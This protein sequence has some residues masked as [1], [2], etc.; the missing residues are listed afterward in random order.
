MEYLN[1]S[2]NVMV[3][4]NNIIPS[5]EFE[6]KI[7]Y[8]NITIRCSIKHFWSMERFIYTVKRKAREELHLENDFDIVEGRETADKIEA[9]DT[10]TFKNKYYKNIPY[11]AF[12]IR[13]IEIESQENHSYQDEED[14]CSICLEIPTERC[15]QSQVPFRCRHSNFCRHCI[16]RWINTGHETCPCCRST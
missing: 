14:V 12:Y 1:H 15:T 10:I 13:P 4:M 2:I 3:I 11:L 7:V 16:N 5:T 9:D 6:F 8:T